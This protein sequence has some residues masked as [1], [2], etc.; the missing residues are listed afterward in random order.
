MMKNI[1]GF[2]KNRSGVG[3]VEYALLVALIGMVLTG[4]TSALGTSISSAL[5]K[6][7]DALSSAPSGGSDPGGVAPATPV[8][9]VAPVVPSAP[10]AKRPPARPF[11]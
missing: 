11:L 4:S 2:F 8:A 3:A 7:L 5:S 9:P 10:P 1:R 6:P